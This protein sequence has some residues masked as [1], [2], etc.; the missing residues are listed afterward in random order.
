M[1]FLRKRA[2]DI[3]IYLSRTEYSTKNSPVAWQ[4]QTSCS[5]VISI[6]L[7]GELRRMTLVCIEYKLVEYK[8]GI[9]FEPASPSYLLCPPMQ[10]RTRR[11][12]LPFL[13]K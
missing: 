5:A 9:A 8:L 12:W 13:A 1:A 11:G 10:S 2:S 4:N 3:T 7:L 6:D